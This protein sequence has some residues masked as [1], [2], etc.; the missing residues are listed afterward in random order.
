MRARVLE[1]L[2]EPASPAEILA[3][4][5]RMARVTFTRA[6]SASDPTRRPDPRGPLRRRAREQ[7]VHLRLSRVPAF[8][9]VPARRLV[10]VG[11]QLLDPTS[12][13]APSPCRRAPRRR[14]HAHEVRIG[15]PSVVATRPG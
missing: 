7:E 12:V 5:E 13:R 6:R 1:E 8:A 11:L 15:A 4:E 10:D 14:R 3:I 9:V 2:P